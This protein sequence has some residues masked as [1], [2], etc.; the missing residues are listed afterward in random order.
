MTR[1]S[2]DSTDP[3]VRLRHGERR[4]LKLTLRDSEAVEKV[5]RRYRRPP[6]PAAINW[7]LVALILG[8]WIAASAW[9]LWMGL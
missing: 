2:P 4:A 1:Y 8:G 5:R 6:A 3:S 9:L 7:S